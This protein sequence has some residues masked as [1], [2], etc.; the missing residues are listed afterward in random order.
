VRF[1]VP[2]HAVGFQRQ[3]QQTVARLALRLSEDHRR[4]LC[5]HQSVSLFESSVLHLGRASNKT[6]NFVGD[7]TAAK[8]QAAANFLHWL[9]AL[10]AN[11]RS[12]TIAKI[13]E[14]R[15][16]PNSSQFAVDSSQLSIFLGV[17]SFQTVN[18]EL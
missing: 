1:G 5:L 4:L 2:F 16:S 13:F 6:V 12:G 10:P 3:L 11:A 17:L 8:N 14:V 9:F 18:C 15:S 7:S